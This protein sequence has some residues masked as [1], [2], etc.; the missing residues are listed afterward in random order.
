MRKSDSGQLIF[1]PSDLIRYMGSPFASWMDR[2]HLE[3]PGKLTPDE[4][5]SEQQLII[6]AG[7]D[8]EQLVLQQF[9]D[10]GL[11]LF[12]IHDKNFESAHLSTRKAIAD[13][14][15]MIFQ[16]ALRLNNWQGFTDFIELTSNGEHVIWDTKLA[17][18]PK[19]YYIIQLCC[20]SEMLAQLTGKT[21]NRFGVIL[22]DQ[23]RV[24][25]RLEELIHYFRQ[26]RQ[27][28]L[29]LQDSFTG[30]LSDGP[31]PLPRAD[32]GRWATHADAYFAERDHLV[33]VAGI[34]IGQIKKLNRAGIHTM[35][36][37]A[38][39][40]DAVV[41][42]LNNDSLRTLAHQARLQVSTREK[43]VADPAAPPIF[44]VLPATLPDGRLN[45]LSQIPKPHPADVFF[46]MEGY[47]LTPGGLEYL[48]GA[49][50]HG[51][52]AG[53]PV[54]HDWW[55]HDRQQEKAAFEGFID[56]VYDR[57][58]SNPQ[59][60]IYHYAPYEVSAV[61]RLSTRH[62]TRQDEVDDLL[63]NGVFV[64]LYQTV[65][66]SL[67]LGED[68]YSIKRVENLY[69]RKR[70]TDVATA[71]DS[72]VQYAA[73]MA[74]DQSAD[75]AN[76]RIL[77]DIRDYNEDDCVS[78]LEL[79]DWLL[80]LAAEHELVGW[81]QHHGEA[82]D[83][84]EN[85]EPEIRAGQ[86]PEVVERATLVERLR[87]LGTD[88]AGSLADVIDYHR[89]EDKPKWWRLF[90]R[91]EA[92]EDELR[93]DPACIA[94]ITPVGDIEPIKRSW[95]Q[96]F[97]FDPNQECKLSGSERVYL[98]SNL[99]NSF[100]LID[101]DTVNGTLALKFGPKVAES[102]TSFEDI[103]RDSIL[104]N[105][106]VPAT[107]IVDS[108]MQVGMGLADSGTLPAAVSAL[109]HRNVPPGL[110]RA[111]SET[112]VEAAQRIALQ[113]DGDC[114]VI[115]G[116]PGTGKTYTASRTIV[117]LLA[118]GKRIGITSNSHKA[119]LNLM[120][121][122]AEAAV[123]AG[124]PIQG[125]KVG[126]NS[127]EA[128]FTEHPP[129]KHV[130][131]NGD[132][133][134]N[135]SGGIVG[136]TAWLFSRSDWAGEL[137]YLFIDEAGQVPLA[138]AVAVAP[139]ANNLVLMGDQMQLEQPIQGTHP[140]DAGMSVLQYALKDLARSLP[141]APVFHSVIPEHQG[142]FLGTTRRMHPAVCNFISDSI[143]E[144]RLTAHPDCERQLI[145]PDATSHVRIEHGIAFSPV[146][147]E[148]NVQRSD[149][150]VGRVVEIF[151]QLLGKAYTDKDGF[152]KP[153]GL[154]D[155]LFI[156]PYNAQVRL[157]KDALP[158]GAKVG[159]VDRFQG[160]E[161]PVCILSLCS[162]A[163]EYGSRGLGFILDKNRINVAISRAKCLAV[164][165]ADPGIAE[166][167]PSGIPEMQ[168]LSLFCRIVQQDRI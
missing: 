80:R 158:A 75:P 125:I 66:K 3:F 115:Q 44:Q 144:G 146:A 65:R 31:E 17:R 113:M 51:A 163:N 154:D 60:H 108:L 37:L 148:G 28:F 90:D 29:E 55:A 89:R 153:L 15:G 38:G 7:N 42:K 135:Y 25:F 71:M 134:S 14:R 13:G 41:P 157:L 110:P 74:S 58:R 145:A 11:D 26:V 20:Y 114:L 106:I 168:L 59:L 84:E 39:S 142:L 127:D 10:S 104:P 63:R 95:M 43:R 21:P 99:R 67:M 131:S 124:Q 86:N 152:T 47:P 68:S 112:E 46:D 2:Y 83:G 150:E 30:E 129:I 167:L 130:K 143:Y 126:G 27:G 96:R 62:D 165:V 35:V 61:R 50:V 48:F 54:F 32:H 151:G 147:H 103:P 53:P 107:A 22:G 123:E 36:Q 137:D 160:Q 18:S 6:N 159:S 12:E 9:R 166:T 23:E 140:G 56:F 116:P 156:A 100:E 162:S 121:A 133:A 79:R 138:N 98:A 128:I 40:A 91:A 109:L 70:D 101:L 5:T 81:S 76:S 24:T 34:S 87:S 92:E 82:A 78:T 120:A 139:A 136:G 4:A 33:Q 97:T 49:I 19:P 161:A 45:G 149:E 122:C 164:V 52:V 111:D 102:F 57:W 72:I 93:D 16:A 94:G 8:H 118:Q 119:I 69:R 77:A 85:P 1:S 105:E 117:A 132:A 155:F 88:V 73:W 64:D 141:D